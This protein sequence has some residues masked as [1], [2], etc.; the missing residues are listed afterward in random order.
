[1]V[2]LETIPEDL[3]SYLLNFVDIITVEGKLSRLNKFWNALINNPKICNRRTVLTFGTYADGCK[4]V[5][6]FNF[7]NICKKYTKIQK[8]TIGNTVDNQYSL[9]I[10]LTTQSNIKE[11]YANALEIEE[12][13]LMLLV[14]YWKNIEVLDLSNNT[15]CSTSVNHLCQLRSLKKLYLHNIRYFYSNIIEAPVICTSLE[16][17]INIPKNNPNLEEFTI[18][19]EIIIDTLDNITHDSFTNL[20]YEFIE[21]I[22]IN[23]PLIKNTNIGTRYHSHQVKTLLIEMIKNLQSRG[24]NIKLNQESYK[25]EV[26]F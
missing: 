10:L 11:V 24:V 23:C 9:M 13:T 3:Q 2:T 26:I 16:D 22:K 19:K 6:T 14:K 18:P 8:V 15:L 5:S 21:A 7:I 17:I 25:I 4:G 1:M 20:F 12:I